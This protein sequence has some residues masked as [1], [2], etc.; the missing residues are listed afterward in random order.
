MRVITMKRTKQEVYNEIKQ[1]MGVVPTFFKS[2][3]EDSLDME[4]QLMKQIQMMDGPIPQKYRELMGIGIAAATKC[5]YCSYF[6]A[7]MAK[8]AGATDEEIQSAVQFAKTVTG[9]STYLNGMQTDF[10]TFQRELQ[11]VAKHVTMHAAPRASAQ[12]SV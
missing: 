8:L 1:M 2:I 7:E 10:P 3:P 12:M 5:K 4:W 9:W 6:H 11:Q